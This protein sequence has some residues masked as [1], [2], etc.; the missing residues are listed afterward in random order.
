MKR[1]IVAY[2]C[3]LLVVGSSFATAC[4]PSCGPSYPAGTRFRVTVREAFAGC[5][6][7]FDKGQT[8]DLVA[9]PPHAVEVGDG[10]AC[11]MNFPVGLPAFKSTEYESRGCGSG[12]SSMGIDCDVV[13]PSCADVSGRSSGGLRVQY[14]ALPDDPGDRVSTELS[15]TFAG[16]QHCPGQSCSA[17]IPVAIAW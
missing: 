1:S 2:S 3:G 11:E 14:G 10:A 8:Y 6:V 5:H 17:R 15:M 12:T 7:T 13:L 16:G 9:E 4:G